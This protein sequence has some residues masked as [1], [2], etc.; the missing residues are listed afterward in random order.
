MSRQAIQEAEFFS[1]LHASELRDVV[2]GVVGGLA[3]RGKLSAEQA[4][5]VREAMEDR[6]VLSVEDVGHGVGVLRIAHNGDGEPHCALVRSKSGIVAT[7]GE[8][9]RFL[10][11][12]IG[13]ESVGV[14]ETGDL[15]A[16]GYMLVDERFG[17]DALS[18][19]STEA[20]LEV[21]EAYLDYLEAPPPEAQDR[22][23]EELARTGRLGGGVLRDMR[24]R[25][26]VYRS[27]FTDGFH[28]KVLAS[29][30]FL[31][32]ACLAPAVAFG[33]LLA[34]LTNGHMGAIEMIVATAVC[35]VVYALAS[36]QPLTI[37]GSTGPVIIF[38]GIVYELC[39]RFGV[40]FFPALSWIGFW[41]ALILVALALFEASSLIRW[42]TRF[43]DE[44]FAALI[45]IIF[46]V[47]ALKDTANGFRPGVP[48]DTALLS[49][50]L[51]LGTFLIAQQLSR[52]RRTPYLVRAAREFL[53]D[54]GPTIA[55][56]AMTGVAF[57]LHPVKLETLAVPETFSTT[58]GRP[59]LVD[60]FQA[61]SW[62][63]GAAAIP[64]VL[65]SV[66][67]FLDQN[68]TVRLVNDR[69]YR[70]KKG[71]GYHLD[72]L[73]VGLLVGV[74]SLFGL[75]WMVAATVRSLNHVRSLAEFENHG[76]REVLTGVRENRVSVLLVHLM[77]GVSLL[78]LT[79]LGQIPMSVLF[80]LFLY[81]GVSSM[82]GNQ[83]FERL[84]LWVLD[85]HRYPPTHYLRRV[86]RRVVHTFTAVQA[87]L[88][89]V[90][91]VVK[92][93]FLGIL[94]PLFIGLLV[95]IRF[96]LGRFFDPKHLA[97]LDAEEEPGEEE[98]REFD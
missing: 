90:L 63:W 34:V 28:P 74:C 52:V 57:W 76:G 94:F 46:I 95:P 2:D 37:L 18:A 87:F 62:V 29:T 14:P 9:I 42:F 17:A 39:E 23:P 93:S 20:L 78:F 48:R 68:I 69:Q 40:A 43:T 72:L 36:G 16:F 66:L 41:T 92:A 6:P 26:A 83:F 3:E 58:A 22:V 56:V 53:A 32:F 59:W 12:V 88:L 19:R 8:T 5:A 75:P 35:G 80:G 91:W 54:F 70:L 7:D 65:V 31:F 15:E 55:I 96:L 61:P 1:D 49:L 44:T 47:E 98:F 71:A 11:V 67:L 38:I 81:M 50:I 60:P 33:G 73:I 86:P 4:R 30:L 25:A 97:F 64:A 45:S 77:V 13:S 27:D 24:R 84:R 21:Y 51:A 85:P 10:W 79:V 89:A 82:H